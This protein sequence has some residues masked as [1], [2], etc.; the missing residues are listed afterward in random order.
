MQYLFLRYFYVIMI[1]I[2]LNIFVFCFFQERVRE[3]EEKLDRI[4]TTSTS[5]HNVNFVEGPKVGIHNSSILILIHY[6]TI[7]T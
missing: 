2:I 4:A 3:L 5:R 7:S 1:P 6:Y